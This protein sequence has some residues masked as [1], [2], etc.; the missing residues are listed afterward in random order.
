MWYG[1]PSAI[2]DEIAQLAPMFAGVSYDRLGGAGGVAVAGAV[3]GAS[4]HL[5]DA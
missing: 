3:E 1:H 2:M 4:R 5:A